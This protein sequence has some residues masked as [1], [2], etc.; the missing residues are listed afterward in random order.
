LNINIGDVIRGELGL[1]EHERIG[2]VTHIHP[3]RISKKRD[4]I[5]VK[6]ILKIRSSTGEWFSRPFFIFEL[7]GCRHLTKIESL[8]W[9]LENNL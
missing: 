7:R 5:Y 9:K 8:L 2:L 4:I 6:Y 3:E 1:I